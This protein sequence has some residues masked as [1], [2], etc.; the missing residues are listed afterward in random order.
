MR[1]GFLHGVARVAFYGMPD[2]V[3]EDGIVGEIGLAEIK[4]HALLGPITILSL[5]SAE[6]AGVHRVERQVIRQRGIRSEVGLIDET[7]VERW[8]I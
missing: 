8:F 7:V 1:G 4:L 6:R 2:D 3:A 5:E